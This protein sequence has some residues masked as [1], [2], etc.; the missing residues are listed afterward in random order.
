MINFVLKDTCGIP[1][2]FLPDFFAGTISIFNVNL[3][4]PRN[5]ASCIRKTQTPFPVIG[6]LFAIA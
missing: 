2:D 5:Q 3:V 6:T 1:R 4:M